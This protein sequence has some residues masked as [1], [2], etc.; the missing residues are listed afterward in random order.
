MK[1]VYVVVRNKHLYIFKDEVAAREDL[2]LY[3]DT[4]MY[5]RAVEVLNLSQFSAKGKQQVVL[6]F[7]LSHHTQ[8]TTYD[9]IAKSGSEYNDWVELVCRITADKP[10]LL[11]S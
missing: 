1:K 5:P 8:R 2:M 9:F 11:H 10:E 4:K 3:D 6:G 7:T